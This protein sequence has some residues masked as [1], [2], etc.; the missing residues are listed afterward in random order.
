MGFMIDKRVIQKHGAGVG[1]GS[2]VGSGIGPA[3]T[4]MSAPFA[5]R[6][7]IVVALVAAL[8]VAIEAVTS[9]TKDDPSSQ[10]PPASPSVSPNGFLR[11]VQAAGTPSPEIPGGGAAEVTPGSKT[12]I[13]NIQ[14]KTGILSADLKV[15]VL[16]EPP[17][18]AED[19]REM[20]GGSAVTPPPPQQKTGAGEQTPG[21]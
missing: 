2:Q 6:A 10:P 17:L 14:V 9:S 15:E 11:A 13:E 18:T 5:L 3:E 21:Q 7:A 8:I 20:E 1:A 4:F 12:R 16:D 19:S